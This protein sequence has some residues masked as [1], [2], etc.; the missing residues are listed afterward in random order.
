[1]ARTQCVPVALLVSG[2][3]NPRPASMYR[4]CT[5]GGQEFSNLGAAC[6]II[7]SALLPL[8]VASS[9]AWLI[10]YLYCP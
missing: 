7:M 5:H 1:M 6:A 9:N 4:C 8:R 10:H 3:V 2:D